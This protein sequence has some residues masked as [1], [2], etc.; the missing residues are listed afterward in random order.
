MDLLD[1]DEGIGVRHFTDQTIYHARYFSD[2]RHSTILCIDVRLQIAGIS[3]DET[4]T[5]SIHIS[6]LV[7]TRQWLLQD[8]KFC[9]FFQ[10]IGGEY[11]TA[12]DNP[13]T[14]IPIRILNHCFK[15]QGPIHLVLQFRRN[16]F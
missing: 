5:G 16:N 3:G 8:L 6:W 14:L 2:D 4:A 13:F 10:V 15:C 11:N 1:M 9:P 7:G 12:Q